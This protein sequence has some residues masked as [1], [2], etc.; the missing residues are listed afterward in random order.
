M[1]ITS[2]LLFLSSSAVMLR[3]DKAILYSRF[4]I[5]LLL[6]ITILAITSLLLNDLGNGVGLFGGLFHTTST[7]QITQIILFL[8]SAVI[9][10]LTAFYPRRSISENS[11]LNKII[12]H[13]FLYYR[14]R[15]ANKMTKLQVSLM[16][17]I[18][19]HLQFKSL[20]STSLYLIISGYL[21]QK[22]GSQHE[23]LYTI[24]NICC[25]IPYA[26]FNLID[27]PFLTH[28]TLAISVKVISRWC[29]KEFWKNLFYIWCRLTIL[30]YIL[31]LVF[32]YLGGLYPDN[33][34]NFMFLAS[35]LKE[36]FFKQIFPFFGCLSFSN[37]LLNYDNVL[38]LLNNLNL[39]LRNYLKNTLEKILLEEVWWPH[40]SS[41]KNV[42]IKRNTKSNAMVKLN[43]EKSLTINKNLS[44]SLFEKALGLKTQ[45]WG[46]IYSSLRFTPEDK[47]K[48]LHKSRL[49]IL[50]PEQIIPRS[51]KPLNLLKYAEIWRISS[52]CSFNSRM[53][54]WLEQ[55]IF[56]SFIIS[57]SSFVKTH[58]GE[59]FIARRILNYL[60]NDGNIIF[61]EANPE[62]IPLFARYLSQL[63]KL[64]HYR[65]VRCILSEELSE[66]LAW[67]KELINSFHL[68]QEVAYSEV[69]V[70]AEQ[71]WALQQHQFDFDAMNGLPP[72]YI[73]ATITAPENANPNTDDFNC[74]VQ[75]LLLVNRLL[76][77]E[78]YHAYTERQN[79]RTFATDLLGLIL[80]NNLNIGR[81]DTEALLDKIRIEY[82]PLYWN[83]LRYGRNYMFTV[84]TVQI[85][86]PPHLLNI[87]DALGPRGQSW[88]DLLNTATIR[89][90]T[91][92]QVGGIINQLWYH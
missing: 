13:E 37:V 60:K 56:K 4:T 1:L 55:N 68:L 22:L 72:D 11:S 82:H 62:I 25:Y 34:I 20:L 29:K 81:I 78:L 44:D 54:M 52:L 69:G 6:Q 17:L 50:K 65:G 67:T 41:E 14:T 19:K 40:Y 73:D 47:W 30:R 39:M 70:F 75:E 45:I 51:T 38:V 63:L 77:D 85:Q 9:I 2:I 31:I 88:L 76:R 59:L 28:Q 24:Y 36:S 43:I 27:T 46:N 35:L 33:C 57:H 80:E 58:S 49:N 84:P 66:R 5:I 12:L 83:R 48:F 32:S 53:S 8:I 74:K 89:N 23:A 71:G 16:N 92:A 64:S 91:R 18:A 90:A 21:F 79:E 15:M 7:I 86:L 87:Y 10:Q 61:S 3:R 42:I 26:L